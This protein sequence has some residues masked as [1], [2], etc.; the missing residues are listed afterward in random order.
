MP[1]IFYMSRQL[2][3]VVNFA[4]ENDCDFSVFVK[5]GLMAPGDIDDRKS[6]VAQASARLQIKSFV[7]RSTMMKH[8]CHAPQYH[9]ADRFIIGIMKYSTDSAHKRWKVRKNTKQTKS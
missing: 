2:P 4:I 8:I 5:D 1:A 9:L 7:I 6:P 3:V